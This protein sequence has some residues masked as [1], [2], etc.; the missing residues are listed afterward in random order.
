MIDNGNDESTPLSPG[1]PAT[2]KA[3][4]SPGGGFLPGRPIEVA[5]TGTGTTNDPS[6]SDTR[7][8]GGPPPPGA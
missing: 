2:P 3:D 7:P 5:A 8:P 6:G 1:S 4:D